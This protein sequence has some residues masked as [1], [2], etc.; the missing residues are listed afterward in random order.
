MV[1]LHIMEQNCVKISRLGNFLLAITIEPLNLLCFFL[2]FIYYLFIYLVPWGLSCGRRAPQLQ[3]VSS[4]VVAGG[5]LSC[6]TP[7][8]HLQGFLVVAHQLLSV[9]R[10]FLSCGSQ[11]PQLQHMG[12]LDV[13]YELLIVAC[14]WGLVP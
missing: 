5:L 2:I 9:A 6:S 11:A 1:I 7:Q 13:A 8:L 14:T 12:S 3:H 10:G 4:L